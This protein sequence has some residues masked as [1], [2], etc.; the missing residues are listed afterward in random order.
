MEGLVLRK[1]TA[2]Y[3]GEN[4]IKD[5]SLTVKPGE[6]LILM[7]ISG[8]GKTTL[9]KT[10]LGI[11]KPETGSITLQGYNLIPL[12]LEMRNIA[13]LPQ[14]YGLFPHMNV[15]RN[16][17]YGLVVRGIK[18]EEQNKI[19][20]EL[21]QKVGLEGCEH[22]KI[23]ELSGGQK[24]RVALARA[25]AINPSLILLD[26]PLSNIDQLTKLEIA[27]YLKLLF[28]TLKIPIILVTHQYE[29]AQFFN[30]DMAILI[31]GVIEQT[32]TYQDILKNPKNLHI[33]Q[34]LTPLS[35]HS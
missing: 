25:L 18:S 22:K 24:Q 32:G 9:L 4:I 21:L 2:G 19:V 13:Y 34:L 12:P 23:N 31:N 35:A 33:K 28:K 10:I 11:I 20:Q 26:E 8:A 27:T 1:V 16:I 7:G 17:A 3:K 15:K 29:D 6:I 5:I 14:D 30:S